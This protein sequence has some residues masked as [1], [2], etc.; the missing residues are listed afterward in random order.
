MSGLQVDLPWN[1]DGA[2]VCRVVQRFIEACPNGLPAKIIIDFRGLGFIHPA[3]VT[4]LSNFI[5]WLRR[6]KGVTVDLAGYERL[7]DAHWLPRRLIVLRAT[8]WATAAPERSA[9]HYD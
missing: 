4:F 3:G 6:A 9:A 8:S 1:L 7:N 2:D 5:H